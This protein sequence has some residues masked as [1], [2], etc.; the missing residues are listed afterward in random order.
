MGERCLILTPVENFAEYFT[1]A[2]AEALRERE[3]QIVDLRYGFANGE[4]HTLQEIGNVFGLTRERIRQLLK[5][6][7]RKIRSKGKRQIAKGETEALCARLLL[8]LE[9]ILR[10]AEPDLLD[11]IFIF[12]RDELAYLP[13][14]THAISLVVFL[15]YGH[16]EQAKKCSLELIKRD[17]EE[18]RASR[19]AIKL[20]AEFRSLLPYIIWPRKITKDL[21]P[22]DLSRKR[23]V[24]PD[25][26]GNSGSFFSQKMDKEVQ[27]E[28]HLEL[29]FL[30]MLEETKEVVLYQ[31]QPFII[32]YISNGRSRNYYPDILFLFEDGKRVV[33]EIKPPYQMALHEN[34]IKLSALRL[35]C[36]QNGWGLLVTNGKIPIQKL[37]HHTFS[38]EFQ[39]ALLEAI[40]NSKGGSISWRE[41]KFIK[42][43]YNATLGDFVAVILKN[44]LVWSLQPFVIKLRSPES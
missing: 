9:N 5:R 35:L 7:L 11:R 23:D 26:I 3:S 27:Y 41:Y 30:L 4:P 31:E 16:Q 43:Q 15:L 20:E 22:M 28:S 38:V 2:Q 25:G 13:Q 12:A 42:D 34:L 18:L 32:P 24:S 19:K 29:Q 17:R 39:T 10:P 14:S 36:I 8:Y 1:L 21:L 40:S 37:H 33:V 44:K 6:S